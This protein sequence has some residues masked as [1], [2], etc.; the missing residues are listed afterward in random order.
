MREGNSRGPRDVVRGC[1]AVPATL[2]RQESRE[3][4]RKMPEGGRA[5]RQRLLETVKRIDDNRRELGFWRDPMACSHALPHIAE[6]YS[7]CLVA[8][9]TEE[10]SLAANVYVAE[11]INASCLRR[12]S[13]LSFAPIWL[14]PIEQSPEGGTVIGN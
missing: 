7:H 6:R 8:G 9:L 5:E 1:T 12:E 3:N 2:H 13:A 14:N 10:D 11:P 4:L